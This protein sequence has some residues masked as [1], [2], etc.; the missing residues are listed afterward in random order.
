ML[1]LT[2]K[3]RKRN[4][5]DPKACNAFTKQ[6]FF[7]ICSLRHSSKRR[8]QIQGNNVL[9]CSKYVRGKKHL[10]V[11]PQ[12][13]LPALELL[14]LLRLEFGE[15]PRNGLV[16]PQTERSPQLPFQLCNPFQTHPVYEP[17]LA[18]ARGQGGVEGEAGAVQL[19]KGTSVKKCFRVC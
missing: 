2:N 4:E 11:E 5:V 10:P 9:I 15:E 8:E 19:K 18:L 17:G 3:K 7:S 6:Y 13:P 12:R 14:S 16:L 1:L